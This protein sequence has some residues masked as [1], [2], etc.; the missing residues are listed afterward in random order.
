MME[1]NQ[2]LL[3]LLAD[4]EEKLRDANFQKQQLGKKVVFLEEL[5]NDLQQVTGH[6]KKLEGQL[7]RISEI[8]SLLART[9]QDKR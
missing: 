1:D 6:Q 7:R 5:S 8:E 9:A 4:T 3:R 2:R